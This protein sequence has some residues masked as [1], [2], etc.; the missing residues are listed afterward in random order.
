MKRK[1]VKNYWKKKLYVKKNLR[2]MKLKKKKY[3]YV[4]SINLKKKWKSAERCNVF[5]HNIWQVFAEK[6]CDE[7]R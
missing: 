4:L 5:K 6:I 7:Y 2:K 3:I 1:I